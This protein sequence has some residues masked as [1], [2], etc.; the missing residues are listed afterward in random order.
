MNFH[1]KSLK[2][3]NCVLSFT[4]ILDNRML[5]PR[6]SSARLICVLSLSRWQKNFLL[7]FLIERGRGIFDIIQKLFTH[8]YPLTLQLYL[9][10]VQY[11]SINC[12]FHE[13]ERQFGQN[14]KIILNTKCSQILPVPSQL[15][16]IMSLD[17]IFF[18][19]NCNTGVSW[20]HD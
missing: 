8:K 10:Q 2:Y 20:I 1:Q 18:H 14:C 3:S 12:N 16:V 11:C 9:A 15:M 17:S 19:S 7:W 6:T 13:T 4:L 5:F